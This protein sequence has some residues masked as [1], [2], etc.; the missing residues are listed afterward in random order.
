YLDPMRNPQMQ[1][2]LTMVGDDIANRINPQFAA[3]GR[4]MSGANQMAVARGIAQGQLPLL[5]DQFNRQ[6]G[7][8]MDAAKSLFDA[9]AGTA[10]TQAQ[11]DAARADLAGQGLNLSNEALNARNLF[12]NAILNLD[13]Q[14]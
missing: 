8:Q 10:V 7:L 1:E 14:I 12:P 3:A 4:D 5:F 6:Q 11:L 13:Q 2:M 9:G